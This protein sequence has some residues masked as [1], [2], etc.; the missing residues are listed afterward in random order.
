MNCLACVR[1][2]RV[3]S[4]G[5]TLI[6]LLVVIAIIAV[7]AALLLPT[8]ASSKERARRVQCLNQMRQLVIGVHLYGSDNQELLPS[9]K[10]EYPDVNDSHI[11]I[12]SGQTRTNLITYAG[13]AR[14]LECPGLGP[15][16]GKLEGWYYPAY[17][18]VLGYNYL[19]G[20]LDTPWPSFR[21]F[22][23]WRSP[24][25]ITDDSSMVLLTDL[26]D[27]SVGYGKT[28]APHGA[29]GPILIGVDAGNSSA[30][31]VSSKTIGAAGGNVGTLSGAVQWVPINKMKPYR[32]S[33]LWGDGGCFALW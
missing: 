10:S 5:F 30:G 31:G 1:I 2:R 4:G 24:Q 15:P 26:N 6:E 13:N 29:N 11:P 22:S 14:L 18:Y 20:H 21:Q 8:L 32:G 19:G 27:W 23:G 12:V 7:L 3:R 9:G 17:G 28:F 33:R 16:F 25:K